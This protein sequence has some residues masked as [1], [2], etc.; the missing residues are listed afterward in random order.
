MYA[1]HQGLIVFQGTIC[2]TSA[3]GLPVNRRRI[4]LFHAVDDWLKPCITLKDC[5]RVPKGGAVC[6]I[7]A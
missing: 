7:G 1:R 2:L 6:P 3:V 4:L 5:D